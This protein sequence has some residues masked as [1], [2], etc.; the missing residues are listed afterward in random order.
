MPQHIRP[1]APLVPLGLHPPVLPVRRGPRPQHRGPLP[2]VR[3]RQPHLA[4]AA[5]VPRRHV[6]PGRAVLSVHRLVIGS[7]FCRGRRTEP[8]VGRG[9]D[10][11][12]AGLDRWPS[13]PGDPPAVWEPARAV[14]A[15]SPTRARRVAALGNAVV[16]QVARVVGERVL[17]LI[18]G[19][20]AGDLAQA[21]G[22][23]GLR[24]SRSRGTL[25]VDS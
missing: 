18:A 16:P 10:G 17:E 4:G 20:R 2:R 22:V 8:G 11:V 12:P 1:P 3:A 7:L 24:P 21:V 5:R 13:R 9:V 19:P 14:S 15:A 25:S 6:H 23:H